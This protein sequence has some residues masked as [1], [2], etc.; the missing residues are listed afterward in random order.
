MNFP[1]LCLITGSSLF[2][3][4]ES[5]LGTFVFVGTPWASPGK[6]SSCCIANHPTQI[7]GM[8]PVLTHLTHGTLICTWWIFQQ[9]QFDATRGQIMIFPWYSHEI[10]P[11]VVVLSSYKLSCYQIACFQVNLGWVQTNPLVEFVIFCRVSKI[12]HVVVVIPSYIPFFIDWCTATII[13]SLSNI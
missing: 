1:V 10:P 3:L 5:I 2:L 4:G 6:S 7:Q 13:P 12:G 8:K 9:A 11:F